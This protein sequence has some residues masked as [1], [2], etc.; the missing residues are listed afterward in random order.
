MAES[1]DP[2]VATPPQP[3][4][5]SASEREAR[6]R[7][8]VTLHINGRDYRVVS[9]AEEAW[10]QDVARRVDGTMA[11]IRDRTETV[12]SLDVAVLTALNLAQEL[13]LL[14]EQS[15]RSLREGVPEAQKAEPDRLRALIELA[16]AAGEDPSARA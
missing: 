7:R 6:T 4:S 8:A 13:I 14:R 15:E 2:S 9:D 11:L 12:D 10:L 3:E 1:I 16:E 5:T